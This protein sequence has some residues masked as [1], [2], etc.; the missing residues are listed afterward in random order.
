MFQYG[1]RKRNEQE[2]SRGRLYWSFRPL[3]SWVILIH[4]QVNQRL[5]KEMVTREEVLNKYE[6]A[7]TRQ[8]FCK[9]H[10]EEEEESSHDVHGT[11]V[12]STKEAVSPW[13]ISRWWIALLIVLVLIVCIVY[14]I[15][16]LHKRKQS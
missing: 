4:N 16:A 7:Y 2:I 6:Q 8:S 15:Y 1:Y 14:I 11:S 10:I 12:I 3:I 5:G 9:T 13:Y